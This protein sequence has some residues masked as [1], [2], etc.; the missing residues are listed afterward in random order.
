M[1]TKNLP[2]TRDTK[3]LR[4][5]VIDITADFS[6]RFK[7]TVGD[8]MID[9]VLELNRFIRRANEETDKEK[10]VGYI[11]ELRY[12]IEDFEDLLDT[13]M[14]HKIVSIKNIASIAEILESIG[15][16]ATGWLKA[17]KK[18]MN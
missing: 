16:Q 2:I 10:R 13:C 5:L 9:V 4:N 1:L 12:L 3:T 14:E 11:K 6:K 17:T 7:Y 8:R 15:K 18:S